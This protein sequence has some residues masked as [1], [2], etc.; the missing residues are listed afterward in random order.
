MKSK[1]NGENSGRKREKGKSNREKDYGRLR[2][3][4]DNE[5]PVHRKKNRKKVK[6]RR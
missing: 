3:V 2:S 1:Q 5:R 6:L 4:N